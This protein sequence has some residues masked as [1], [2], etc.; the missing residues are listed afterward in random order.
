MIHTCLKGGHGDCEVH[1]AELDSM[2]LK[3]Q[4]PVL[5]D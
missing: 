3:R 1:V 5:C 2:W 4:E